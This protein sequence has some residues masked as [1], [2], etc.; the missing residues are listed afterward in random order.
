VFDRRGD[1]RHQAR[2]GAVDP[3]G[4]GHELGVAP[5]LEAD[6]HAG[7]A[8]GPVEPLDALFVQGVP[9][10]VEEHCAEALANVDGPPQVCGPDRVAPVHQAALGEPV[11]QRLGARELVLAGLEID[12]V[13]EALHE[14]EG[15]RRRLGGCGFSRCHNWQTSLAGGII[16]GITI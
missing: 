1:D 16:S 11:A 13:D 8:D 15:L 4:I 9:V 2:H 14:V 6:A 5:A 7:A 12:A 10:V 3:L